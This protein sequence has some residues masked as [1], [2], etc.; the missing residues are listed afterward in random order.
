MLC[1]AGRTILAH[2]AVNAEV[3][4]RAERSEGLPLRLRQAA[5]HRQLHA[6]VDFLRPQRVS[7]CTHVCHAYERPCL[8]T[9]H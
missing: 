7:A 3:A 8:C 1:T 6:A 2:D 4:V 9:F 5:D